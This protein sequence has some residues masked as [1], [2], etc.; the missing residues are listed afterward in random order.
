M[1]VG[2][3]KGRWPGRQR[4]CARPA[5]R[6][7]LGGEGCSDAMKA[8]SSMP[9]CSCDGRQ[10]SLW[11][12]PAG[13]RDTTPPCRG[14]LARDAWCVGCAVVWVAGEVPVSA[15]C[16]TC[17]AMALMC[18]QD[19][20]RTM[21]KCSPSFAPLQRFGA[22]ITIL[23]HSWQ[24]SASPPEKHQL[25]VLARLNQ[26]KRPQLLHYVRSG[27]KPARTSSAKSS[28][29]SQAAKCPPLSSRL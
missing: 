6:A 8:L 15:P 27:L 16:V 7:S 1:V 19:L 17:A 22:S 23:Y 5:L 9:F 4:V 24:L 25:S 20:L 26:T 29:C 11:Y 13:W 2:S 21:K 18:G 14:G 10:A 3:S 12:L 28:G